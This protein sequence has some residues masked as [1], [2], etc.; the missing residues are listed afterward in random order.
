MNSFKTLISK[1]S[2]HVTVSSSVH[3]TGLNN[4][5]I[6]AIEDKVVAFKDC[7]DWDPGYVCV[8]TRARTGCE[9]KSLDQKMRQLQARQCRLPLKM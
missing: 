3:N 4:M 7:P 1:M 8:H 6:K 5:D 2:K 9:R